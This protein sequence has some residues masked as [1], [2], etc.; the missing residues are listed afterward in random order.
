VG[1]RRLRKVLT[2]EA[3]ARAASDQEGTIGGR[4]EQEQG[5]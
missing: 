4:I 1:A 2:V 5:C 3:N